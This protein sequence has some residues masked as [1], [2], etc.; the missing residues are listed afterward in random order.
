M[1]KEKFLK[2]SKDK[3]YFKNHGK[4]LLALSGGQDS[5]TLFN[6]LYEYKEELSIELVLAHVNYNLRSSAGDEAENLKALAD[7]KNIKIEIIKYQEKKF[8]EEL[9]RQFRYDF[10]KAMM[11]KH[12]CTVLVTAHHQN[13]QVETILMREITGRRL[14]HL[15]GISDCQPFANGQLIRPL[16]FFEKSELDA[17]YFF[18]DSSNKENDYLR[19]RIRNQIIPQ[20]TKENP[21][22]ISAILDL[23]EEISD[24]QSVIKEKIESLQILDEKIQLMKFQ[25][26]SSALKKFILQEYLEKYF[27]HL[28]LNKAQFNEILHILEQDQQYHQAINKT[29]QL[30]KTNESFSIELINE[31]DKKLRVSETDPKDASYMK[32]VLAGEG[33]ITFRKRQSGDKIM[34]HGIHKKLKNYLIDKKIALAKRENDLILVNDEIFAMVDVASFDLSKQAESDK[35]KRVIWVK[36]SQN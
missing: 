10:F 8:T 22:F 1:S 17:P 31:E 14:R 35:M 25:S 7:S 27:S 29:H 15:T 6:W 24:A 5:M 12:N 26:Q 23:R 34:V 30:I 11:E 16:L 9:G 20:L 33:R 2:I 36:Y 3:E 32:I 18:E 13:D 21:Q 19:N 28:Q 4:V